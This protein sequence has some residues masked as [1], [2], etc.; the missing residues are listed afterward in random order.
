MRPLRG[1]RPLQG[2]VPAPPRGI[3]PDIPPN[4]LQRMMIADDGVVIRS[5]PLENRL[6]VNPV[7]F[8]RHR[9]L[10]LLNNF[11]YRHFGPIGLV[12]LWTPL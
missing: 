4:T 3:F 5:L 8:A 1:V 7:Y 12:P 2:Y 10:V 11:R 9:G 6:S